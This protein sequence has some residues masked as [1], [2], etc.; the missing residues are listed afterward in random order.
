MDVELAIRFQHAEA[1]DA[2]R[3]GGVGAERDADAGHLAANAL[4][5]ALIRSSQ[6]NSARPLSSTR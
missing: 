2:N 4:A 6:L 3:A 1:I 5:V